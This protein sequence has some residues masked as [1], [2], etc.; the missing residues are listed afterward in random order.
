[1]YRLHSNHRET[2]RVPGASAGR[3]LAEA[4]TK[5]RPTA[6]QRHDAADPHRCAPRDQQTRVHPG[7]R[8]LLPP[9]GTGLR[10]GP[11]R[12][13]RTRRKTRLERHTGTERDARHHGLA[14]WR[15]SARHQGRERRSGD[16]RNT[17]NQRPSRG[18]HICSHGDGVTCH[19]H[20]GPESNSLVPVLGSGKPL[21]ESDLAEGEWIGDK[22]RK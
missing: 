11:P 4:T 6:R 17:G 19:E 13:E 16:A 20:S 1:M 12:A 10:Q 15:R 18:I 22:N 7:C 14:W 5:R 21:T 8:R 2:R 3:Q 9:P